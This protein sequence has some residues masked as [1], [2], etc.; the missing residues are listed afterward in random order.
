M[1]TDL[2]YG[3]GTYL[4]R[5]SMKW[6]HLWSSKL[7]CGNTAKTE[8]GTQTSREIG[9]CVKR[10]ARH[11]EFCEGKYEVLR[12]IN[13]AKL[14]VYMINLTIL[15]DLEQEESIQKMETVYLKSRQKRLVTTSIWWNTLSFGV[16]SKPM[17][18]EVQ[19]PFAKCQLIFI[20]IPQVA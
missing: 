17:I 15:H 14:H 16:P 19:W 3:C 6:L 1:T 4:E 9:T 13:L 5:L 7:E 12:V 11:C 10:F 18:Y 20:W 8:T 2:E